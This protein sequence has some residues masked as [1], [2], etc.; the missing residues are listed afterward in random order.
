MANS[1][2][3]L[4]TAMDWRGMSLY[5][6][7]IIVKTLL[8]DPSF[9]QVIRDNLIQGYS[10]KIALQHF[11]KHSLLDKDWLKFETK[12]IYTQPTTYL[13]PK[14]I[15]YG[16]S[17]G[18]IL[19][20]GYSA[21]LGSTSLLDQSILGAP[22]TP[23]ALVLTRSHDFVFY[24]Y[25]FRLNLYNNRHVRIIL[26]FFQMGWDSV[27]ASGHL[28]P[29]LIDENIPRVLIQAGFGDSEVT[30]ISAAVLARAYKA[31]LL[32]GHPIGVFG[33]SVEQAAND[34]FS[35]PKS[36]FTEILYE[37]D[38]QNLPKTNV[39]PAKSTP[40]HQCI[41]HDARLQQQIVEFI[42]NGR[43]IDPC[44][45]NRCKFKKAC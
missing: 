15:F 22:G 31:S 18:G 27:G 3:Y 26:S 2:G 28:S 7:P 20:A 5:D 30:T 14:M 17:Q 25:L 43:I 40:V 33:L 37:D 42:N 29:P 39:P 44:A 24:N 38:R 34:T 12:E 41:R 19:G 23:F 11:A 10:N 13:Q 9:F 16:I 32:P 36:A 21:L 8:S 6:L 35:G 45:G 4:I 1:N